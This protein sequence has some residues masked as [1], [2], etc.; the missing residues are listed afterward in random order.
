MFALAG[1]TRRSLNQKSAK[2]IS[3]TD[4]IWLRHTYSG[5]TFTLSA[6]PFIFRLCV[7][8]DVFTRQDTPFHP[9]VAGQAIHFC[10]NTFYFVRTTPRPHTSLPIT[11]L[12]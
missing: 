4:N 12:N 11:K 2:L 9:G 5:F 3:L 8:K 7:C 10:T 1:P 6:Q